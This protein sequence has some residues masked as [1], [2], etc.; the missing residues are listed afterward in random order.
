MLVGALDQKSD[1]VMLRLS[2]EDAEDGDVQGLALVGHVGGD[3]REDTNI[4][5]FFAEGTAELSADVNAEVVN[6]KDEALPLLLLALCGNV[7]GGGA[8]AGDNVDPD[9]VHQGGYRGPMSVLDELIDDTGA[10]SRG[11]AFPVHLRGEEIPCGGDTAQQSGVAMA[12][13]DLLVV[14]NVLANLAG[15]VLPRA[16]NL[17]DS[18]V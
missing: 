15:A 11:N 18:L 17:W 4:P 16:G 7:V 13:E 10:N 6:D 5:K 14:R 3:E 9:V 8:E 1:V 2:L 12:L